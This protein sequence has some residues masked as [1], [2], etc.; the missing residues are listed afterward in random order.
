MSYAMTDTEYKQAK[1]TDLT[2]FLRSQGQ[3]LKRVG[4]EYLWINAGQK[5]TIRSHMWFNHY[6]HVGGDAISFVCRYGHMDFGQAVSYLLKQ[7]GRCICTAAPRQPVKK[8][9][10][11]P[12]ASRSAELVRY[13]LQEERQIAPEILQVFMDKGLIYESA[14]YHNAVFVGRD[15]AGQPR[16][17]SLRS[18]TG[19]TP[20]KANVGGSR[21]EYSFHWNGKSAQ[22]YV[23]EAPVDLLSFISMNPENWQQHSYAACCGVCDRVLFQMLED[24]PYI[25]TVFL[26]LDNDATGRS[27]NDRIAAKLCA[28]GIQ[29]EILVPECKDWNEDLV[30]EKEEENPCRT[31]CL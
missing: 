16:H 31:W 5:I 25:R 20:F 26:C 7:D 14:R 8:T 28:R 1:Y 27:A 15:A 17:A 23:F 30:H 21:P 13:Y 9:F 10:R 22:L 2:S 11:L 12:A 18:V 24:C 4:S 3:E 6:E 29:N 19:K